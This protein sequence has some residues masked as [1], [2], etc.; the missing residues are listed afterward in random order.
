MPL[1]CGSGCSDESGI[2]HEVEFYREWPGESLSLHPSTHLL[3][4][5]KGHTMRS[6]RPGPHRARVTSPQVPRWFVQ[7]CHHR[8]LSSLGNHLTVGVFPKTDTFSILERASSLME[9]GV[10]SIYQSCTLVLYP[11]C[12]SFL[13]SDVT[14][15]V[16]LVSVVG[17]ICE[18]LWLARGRGRL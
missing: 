12:H 11:E 9:K 18:G 13:L 4:G 2:S 10:W 6:R 8:L 14:V 5:D 15:S 16:M 3:L 17:R 1:P 7:L